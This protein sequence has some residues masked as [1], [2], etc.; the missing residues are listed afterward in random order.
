[1]ASQ[2][3]P[4]CGSE[5]L[6]HMTGEYRFDPPP[7]IPGGTI[8]VSA[9]NWLTCHSCGEDILSHD[10]EEAIDVARYQRL[11]LLSPGEI[12]KVRTKTGLSSVDMA[13]LLGVGEKTYTRWETG[14]SVQNKANDNLI[15]F[16]DKN[17]KPFVL[18]EAERN[19]QRRMMVKQ[20]LS[21]LKDLKGSNEFAMAAHGGDLS[22]LVRQALRER[23]SQLRAAK[24]IG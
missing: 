22:L 2:L 4:I 18:V 12:R 7:N 3:C 16:I 23:L 11:G 9:T 24:D 20:Y 14:R 5:A 21:A 17:P 15:R 10:L 19:P 8:V 6:K 1:M 13:H